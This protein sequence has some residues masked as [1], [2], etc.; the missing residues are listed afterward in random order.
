MADMSKLKTRFG[1]PPEAAAS[2]NLRQPEEAVQWVDGRSLRAKG[3]TSQLATRI[4]PEIHHRA[5][6][7]AA[8]D[9]ITMAELIEVGIR[10]YEAR[11]GEET[12]PTT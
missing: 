12:K 2:D 7:M 5:K 6:V 10:L 9:G 8:Q 11:R 4:L 3:R 1:P